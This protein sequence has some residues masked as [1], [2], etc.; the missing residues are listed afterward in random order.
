VSHGA[1]EEIT[2]TTII[3][4]QRV[5]MVNKGVVG[6]NY[7]RACA[8]DPD[9]YVQNNDLLV[10]GNVGIGTTQPRAI[11][12]INSTTSGFLPPRMTTAQRNA[13]SNPPKG[14][15]IYNMDAGSEGLNHYD[16]TLWAPLGGSGGFGE[17]TTKDSGGNN[18][19]SGVTYKATG[20]GFFLV[21]LVESSNRWVYVYSGINAGSGLILR[22][23]VTSAHAAQGNPRGSL[24][25]PVKSGHYLRITGSPDRIFWMPMGLG[26]LER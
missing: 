20:D 14:S 10:E 11:L 13:I 1:R 25:L 7:R 16:G 6:Y 18:L 22:G 15:I 12:D 2:L 26:Q 23:L 24:T 3:P 19:V 8:Q 5:L 21:C 17:W 9:N 4:D